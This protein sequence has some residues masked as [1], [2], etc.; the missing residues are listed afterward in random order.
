MSGLVRCF[1]LSREEFSSLQ[2]ENNHYKVKLDRLEVCNSHL[3]AELGA[4]RG[5]VDSEDDATKLII[6]QSELV[7]GKYH[8]CIQDLEL[9]VS[10][11]NDLTRSL[12]Q[13]CLKT[14]RPKLELLKQELS[15]LQNVVQEIT[16]CV[17]TDERERVLCHER[18]D[19]L[20]MQLH[21]SQEKLEDTKRD[22]E[23]KLSE[24]EALSSEIEE[25]QKHQRDLKDEIRAMELKLELRNQAKEHAFKVLNKFLKDAFNLVVSEKDDLEKIAS[26]L[27]EIMNRLHKRIRSLQNEVRD[28]R[29]ESNYRMNTVYAQL[30]RDLIVIYLSI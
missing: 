27:S 29:N 12:S 21:T 13:K 11:S 17:D 28:A 19:H 23:Q 2:E 16:Q 30:E 7:F 24:N 8:R 25:A 9:M 1:S 3:Q 15:S 4:L 5:L 6:Q 26:R 14:Q 10:S 18:I 20:E 22:L